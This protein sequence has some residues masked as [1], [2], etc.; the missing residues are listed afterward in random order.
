MDILDRSQFFS[1]L[2]ITEDLFSN[3][4]GLEKKVKEPEILFEEFKDPE[5]LVRRNTNISSN[6]SLSGIIKVNIVDA[7]HC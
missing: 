5:I 3:Y 4:D 7:S 6:T 1:G 2:T